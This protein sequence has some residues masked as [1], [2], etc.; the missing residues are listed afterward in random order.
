M[1]QDMEQML[2]EVF[3]K[4][5]GSWPLE[6]K[7][8]ARLYQPTTYKYWTKAEETRLLELKKEG[9]TYKQIAVRLGRSVRG[10]Q[11]RGYLLGKSK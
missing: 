1:Q 10:T 7:D 4:V 2:D 5:L 8:A 9:L 11:M 6:E 3:A